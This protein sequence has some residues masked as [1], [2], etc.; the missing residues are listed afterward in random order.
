MIALAPRS[1]AAAALLIGTAACKQE[2]P[3]TV[4]SAR[5]QV[6]FAFPQTE[7]PCV[8]R[9]TV[10][11]ADDRRNPLWVIDAES[12]KA[13]VATIRYGSPPVGFTQRGGLNLLT[14][15]KLHLVLVQRPGEIGAQYFEPGREGL[16]GREVPAS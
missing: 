8:D 4:T 5:G 2:M 1:L 13:C 7:P 16:I 11:R 6:T 15:G 10:Y 3:V 9:L 14:D 12:P